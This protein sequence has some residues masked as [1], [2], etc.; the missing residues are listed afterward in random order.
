[1]IADLSSVSGIGFSGF[2][3]DLGVGSG[4]KVGVDS[5]SDVVAPTKV[6]ES[7]FAAMA[8]NMNSMNANQM[9]TVQAQTPEMWASPAQAPSGIGHDA[10]SQLDWISQQDQAVHAVREGKTGSM[11]DAWAS[12]ASSQVN[13]AGAAGGDPYQNAVAGFEHLQVYAAEAQVL[14]TTAHTI[15]STANSLMKGG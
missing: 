8:D 4:D 7:D 11:S 1:M 15:P 3:S 12:S 14:G 9:P 5:A 13:G 2:G 10:V 6:A